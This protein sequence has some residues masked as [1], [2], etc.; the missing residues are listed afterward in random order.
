MFSDRVQSIIRSGIRAMFDKAKTYDDALYLCIGEPGF[1]TAKDVC[2][3]AAD[4]LLA[5]DTKYT[6]NAGLYELREGIAEKLRVENKIPV[7]SVNNILVTVGATEALFLAIMA[8]VNPGEEVIYLDPGWTNY[9][10]QIQMAGGIPVP[11]KTQEEMGF[12]V[13]A[14]DIEAAITE[15]TKLLLLNSPCNP[16]GALLTRKDYEDIATVVKK[17]RLMVL[18][19]EPYE[20]IVFDGNQHVSL[21]SLPGMFEHCITINC[22]SKTFA[23]TGWRVG[24]VCAHEDVIAQM[25][26][27]QEPVCSCVSGALQKGCLYA[28]NHS[29][30]YIQVMMDTYKKNRDIMVSALNTFKGFSCH[31]PPATFYAFPNIKALGKSSQDLANEIL[32][33]LHVVTTPGSAFYGSVGEGHLR[34]SFASS[35]EVM[36]RALDRMAKKFC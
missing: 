7:S 16:T 15:N 24:Y 34:L 18:C 32:E 28:L 11:V 20:K 10:Q 27:I 13:K 33:E 36:E 35:T 6:Q 5:G 2:Q 9:I 30:E 29:K 26:K 3:V 25:A 4:A 23:M 8:M 21:A 31:I 12:R 17:H 22:F 1:T 19:D 14:V